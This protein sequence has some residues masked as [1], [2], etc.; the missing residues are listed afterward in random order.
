[1]QSLKTDND[2]SGAAAC[3]EL[4]SLPEAK[5]GDGTFL[6]FRDRI[7]DAPDQVV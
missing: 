5:I 7:A 1:M 4:E 2:L 6:Q 3:S